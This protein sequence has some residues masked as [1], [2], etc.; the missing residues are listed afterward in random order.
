VINGVFSTLAGLNRQFLHAFELVFK[1]PVT[2]ELLRLNAPLQD[3][4]EC[5]L[6]VSGLASL[7]R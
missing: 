1:H 4:L 3:D 7:N 5:A 6:K 2:G